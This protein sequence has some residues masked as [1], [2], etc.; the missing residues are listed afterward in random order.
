MPFTPIGIVRALTLGW[1]S[2]FR[3]I[4]PLSVRKSDVQGL[5]SSL[6]HMFRGSYIVVI[7]ESGYGKTCLIDTALNRQY[8]VVKIS[9]S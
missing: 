8:G 2:Y 4:K 5:S 1:K 7:G 3:T 6:Q 9:V